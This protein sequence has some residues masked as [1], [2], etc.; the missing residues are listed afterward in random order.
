MTGKRQDKKG[1]FLGKPE[2]RT[3]LLTTLDWQQ[4][5]DCGLKGLRQSL[6]SMAE[7][8]EIRTEWGHISEKNGYKYDKHENR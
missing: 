3:L 4:S 5:P 8:A 7:R 6:S 1:Y 2:P